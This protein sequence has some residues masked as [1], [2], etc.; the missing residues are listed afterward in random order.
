MKYSVKVVK[1]GEMVQEF[2]EE[3]MLIIFNENAPEELAEISVLHTI[4]AL[5]EDVE[6]GDTIEIGNIKY[7]VV[8]V[9]WEANK[10]LRE[11]GHCT[12]KFKNSNTADLPGVINLRGEELK[13]I[14][15]GETISIY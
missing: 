10:T 8:A 2:I 1:L 3:K 12:L 11:L 4:D 14:K 13:E 5:K 9:G 7:E 6:V 15:I